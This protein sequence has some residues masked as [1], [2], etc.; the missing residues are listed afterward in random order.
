MSH[1]LFPREQRS[2]IGDV[3][4][5]FAAKFG[6]QR[7]S[8][9]SR[10][11][12][13][14]HS[15][16]LEN[17]RYGPGRKQAGA[18]GYVDRLLPSLIADQTAVTPTTTYKNIWANGA[19]SPTI[20]PSNFWQ[21]GRTLR[22]TV[23]AKLTTGTA[24]NSAFSMAYGAADAPAAVCATATR[25]KIASVGPF[26]IFLQGY[27][28]CRLTGTTG[29]LSMWGIAYADL[30]AFLST[31]QP[32]VFPASGTTVVSTIDTTVGT[33][34]LFFQYLTSAGTDSI[35]TTDIILEWLGGI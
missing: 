26:G 5:R 12:A 30:G 16:G 9:S 28:T 20:L 1:L 31:V 3:A 7:A 34:S 13:Q 21:V 11:I 17:Y 35:Q 27:A 14:Y 6:Y 32:F 25:A 22:L 4:D 2:F 33:N 10:I 19:T 15:G 8:K 18:V 24:G 23:N 29:T